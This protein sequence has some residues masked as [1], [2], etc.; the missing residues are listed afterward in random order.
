MTRNEQ[1]QTH[2]RYARANLA[3][4]SRRPSPRDIILGR[5]ARQGVRHALK[6]LVLAKGRE[7]QPD[8]STNRLLTEAGVGT[9]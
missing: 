8:W 9:D 3:L 6:A 5:L 1:I 2:K 7:Y 4:M